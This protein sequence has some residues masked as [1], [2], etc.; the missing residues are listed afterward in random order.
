L[1][2]RAVGGQDRVESE[3]REVATCPI[4]FEASTAAGRRDSVRNYENVI[5][6]QSSIDQIKARIDRRLEIVGRGITRRGQGA[7]RL[8]DEYGCF[9]PPLPT[10]VAK[11]RA[12]L[13][14]KWA[15][16]VTAPPEAAAS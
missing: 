10:P 16:K 7:A 1:N 6:Q 4:S 11:R 13:A 14:L 12:C 2:T 9:G 8:R 5:R 15:I 3:L